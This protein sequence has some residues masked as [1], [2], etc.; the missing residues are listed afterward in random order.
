MKESKLLKN[1]V[2]TFVVL[3]LGAPALVLANSSSHLEIDTVTVSYA[4]LNLENEAGVQA[5]YGRLQR[6]SNKVCSAASV[7]IAGL[8]QQLQ[9]DQCYR[10]TLAEAVESIDNSN[11]TRVHAG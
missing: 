9:V 8:I 2:A 7:Q 5:L 3:S 10:E 6:A 4:D 1:L 11:L